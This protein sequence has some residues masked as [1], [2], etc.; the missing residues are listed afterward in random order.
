VSL[1]VLVGTAGTLT[2][3]LTF[4]TVKM[5]AFG[6]VLT[7]VKFVKIATFVTV[8]DLTPV[9]A[10]CVTLFDLTPVTGVMVFDLT[11]V[12]FLTFGACLGVTTA[13]VGGS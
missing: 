8:S 6:T 11:S 3:G 9:T 10:A 7:G 5:S 13:V 12:T 2:V 1:L 4:L